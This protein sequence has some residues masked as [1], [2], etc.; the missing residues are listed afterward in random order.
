LVVQQRIYYRSYCLSALVFKS[1]SLNA[2]E[3]DNTLS[4]ILLQFFKSLLPQ[5]KQEIQVKK[6]NL[7][8][9]NSEQWLDTF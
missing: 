1:F 4:G 3:I 8:N 6:Y 9:G 2:L 5:K 7:C